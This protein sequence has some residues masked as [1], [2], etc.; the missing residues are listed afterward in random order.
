MTPPG[1][2]NAPRDAL[3]FAA[4]ARYETLA[5][6][7][8]GGMAEVLLAATRANGVVKLSVLKCLWPELAEDTDFVEMFLDE[9]RLCA[10][11][12]HPNVVQTHEIVQH[13]GRLA[14]AM[15]YLDGQALTSVLTR[16][17][18]APELTLPMRL[19]IISSVLAGLDYA[20]KLTDFDGTPL[21]VVHRDV[22]PHNVIVTY[23]GHVKLLDFGVA[24][25]LA[26]SHQTR[27]G[28]IKG[29]LAYLA[30]EAVRGDRVDRR[31]D[32]FSVGVMLWEILAG[33]RLWGRKSEGVSGAWRLAAGEL[34]PEL[35][36]ELEI[37]RELRAIC[38]R[39]LSTDPEARYRTA[40]QLGAALED[41]GVDA[42]ESD[43]RRLGRLVSDT[44]PAERAQ[45]RALV[46]FHLR[47]ASSGERGATFD[48]DEFEIS[49]LGDTSV[50]TRDVAVDVVSN[51]AAPD[52][53]PLSETSTAYAFIAK[54]TIAPPHRLGRRLG[55]TG[56]VAALALAAGLYLGHRAPTL[57]WLRATPA[58]VSATSV[59]AAPQPRL[60]LPPVGAAD[61]S[62]GIAPMPE[63]HE[64]QASANRERR[65]RHARRARALD[66]LS[67]DVLGLDG[68]P[69]AQGPTGS[70]R[71]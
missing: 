13:E 7:G 18:G 45:R 39:A 66:L 44:F 41:V 70:L 71:D 25:T 49:L 6:I 21:E 16:L 53:Y 51:D 64:S 47:P 5:R 32:I 30:P 57:T 59:L 52:A 31:A 9:A 50:H 38:A 10:R 34:A 65:E 61:T 8:R 42:S 62:I 1:S 11:L 69:L 40:A 46:E 3:D 43:A 15:E 24:K 55:A 67:D 33:R 60:E 58:S 36:A 19:R 12:S 2:Q 20:H 26:A 28:G 56:A 48:Y 68:E 17:G 23:D 27:P 37:P 22:S 14:L 63:A 54:T 29:K 4:P 35:P